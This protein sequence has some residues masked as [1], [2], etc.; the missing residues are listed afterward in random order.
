MQE[1]TNVSFLVGS[2]DRSSRKKKSCNLKNFKTSFSFSA[3]LFEMSSCVILIH[4]YFLTHIRGMPYPGG[5]RLKM[6]CVTSWLGA[7]GLA[8][9]DPQREWLYLEAS[10]SVSSYGV[11]SKMY[12]LHFP[13][14]STFLSLG[15]HDR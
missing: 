14:P 13:F 4:F 10:R 5:E 3:N 2:K 11:S 7:N 8:S 12:S 9:C 1:L 6:N 15:R